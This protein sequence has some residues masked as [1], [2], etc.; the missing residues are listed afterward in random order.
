MAQTAKILRVAS[1]AATESDVVDEWGRD[2]QLIRAFRPL[3]HLRWDVSIT[4]TGHLPHGGALIIVNTRRFALTLVAAAWA[5]ADEIHRPVRFVGRPDVVPLGPL[6][7]RGGGLLAQPAEVAGALRAG[8][9]VIV[10]TA[11]TATTRHAGRVDATLVAP[12]IR[13]R[14][15][16]HVAATTSSSTT[17]QV[18]IEISPALRVQRARRGP[19]AEVELADYARR[20]LQDMLTGP[21]RMHVAEDRT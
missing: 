3:A 18:G 8:E 19:L 7:R 5:I 9:L 14:V 21:R 13:E 2:R 6:L 12:A 4:G 10:G 20:R 1:G 11:A 17:R 16:V 15:P